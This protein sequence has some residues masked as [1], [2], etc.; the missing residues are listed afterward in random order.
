M[1][2]K[3]CSKCGYGFTYGQ[4]QRNMNCPECGKPAKQ[5]SLKGIL[6]LIVAIILI[7]KCAGAG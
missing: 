4:Y 3:K 7:G 2:Y 5:F 6:I 1:A